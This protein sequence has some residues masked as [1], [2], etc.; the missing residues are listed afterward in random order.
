MEELLSASPLLL[1][2]KMKWINVNEQYLD[3]LRKVEKRIP[4]TDY[5]E[6]RYK[7]FFGILFEKDGLYYITQ[8][9]HAQPRHNKLKQQKDFY[10]VY[11]PK[12]PTRLIAVINLN[13]MFPIP[14]SE[15]FPFE[16]NQI[17]TYRTFTSEKEKSKYIDLLDIEL[18]AINSMDI[19][20]KAK[21]LYSLKCNKPEHVV[22]KRCIDFK[23]ME[24][25]A[26]QYKGE[27]K[28]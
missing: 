9:S 22:S 20:T 19:G 24:R 16:K 23:N 14:K 3:Y 15:V 1:E 11:D 6:D 4:R 8:V 27:E 5:G 25:L 7:P 17:H 13:Y 18:S 12:S 26:L 21:E 10:K 28:S 2:Q